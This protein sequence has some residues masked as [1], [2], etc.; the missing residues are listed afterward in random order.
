MRGKSTRL[1]GSPRL[2][3]SHVLVAHTSYLAVARRRVSPYLV[4]DVFRPTWS[5]VCSPCYLDAF[6]PDPIGWQDRWL[7]NSGTA[8]GFGLTVFAGFNFDLIVSSLLVRR[9][10]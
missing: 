1:S 6:R 8:A 2:S 7:V 10:L 4:A 3:G 9:V 5:M